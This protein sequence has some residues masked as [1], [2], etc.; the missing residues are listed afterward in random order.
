MAT[1]HGKII[2][3]SFPPEMK[4]A[5][6][7]KQQ[8]LVGRR[9]GT[10]ETY[11]PQTQMY[12][13]KFLDNQMPIANFFKF[14]QLF[15]LMVQYRVHLDNPIRHGNVRAS[16]RLEL[17]PVKWSQWHQAIT[18][19]EVD[20][21]KQVRFE[22]KSILTIKGAQNIGKI[23]PTRT[24][25]YT[26]EDVGVIIDEVWELATQFG[27]EREIPEAGPALDEVKS[28]YVL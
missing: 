15:G 2:S 21:G 9:I 5:A 12:K 28:R 25:Q 11:L 1:R 13:V 20:N 3:K 19:K 14:E 10:V 16:A 8:V 23:I 26:G 27:L 17:S 22:L 6:M 7:E 4:G 24:R 18:H